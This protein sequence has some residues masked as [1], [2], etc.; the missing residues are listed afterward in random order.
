M[1]KGIKNLF[2][3]GSNK[4]V[5][6]EQSEQLP[7]EVESE[8]LAAEVKKT[9]ERFFPRVDFSDPENFARYG[10]AEKYYEDAISHIYKTFPYDGSD[11]EKSLWHREA[12]YL[13]NWFFDTLYPR[14]TGYVKLNSASPHSTTTVGGEGVY[15]S[16]LSPQHISLKGGPH[17]D[18]SA[19]GTPGKDEMSKQFPAKD[20][21]A[22]IWEADNKKTSNLEFDPTNGNTVEFWLKYDDANIV[23]SA[24]TNRAHVLFDMWNGEAIGTSGYVRFMVERLPSASGDFQ[25]TYMH[26]T[27]GVERLALSLTATSAALPENAWQHV[28]IT[29]KNSGSQILGQ[30]YY[31]G[32]FEAQAL[33]GADITTADVPPEGLQARIN[34]YLAPPKAGGTYAGLT[35]GTGGA[36]NVYF[37]EFRYWK[38]ERAEKNIGRFWFTQIS[39]GTNTDVNKYSGS[40]DPIDL[41][42]YYKFNEG[43]VD[44]VEVNALDA[45]VIDYSGRLSNGSISNYTVQVRSTGSAM[46]EATQVDSDDPEYKDPVLYSSHPS[47]STLM[48]TMKL[49]GSTHDMKNNAAFYHTMPN[50]ITEE[51]EEK[52]RFAIKELVQA[53]SSYFDTL[54]LQIE[55]LPN[56]KETHYSSM[57]SGTDKPYSFVNHLV[58]S[59]GMEAPDLF[60]EATAL[61][62]VMS[63]GEQEV[64]DL[65]IQEIKNI[66]YQN[67]YNNL[68][69]I[70]KSKGTEK[71]FRNLIRCFGVDEELIKINL[72]ADNTDYTLKDTKRFTVIKKNFMDCNDRDRNEGIA[73]SSENDGRLL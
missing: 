36:E 48:S 5:T 56:M 63:R 59:L 64:F 33:G 55:A 71:A 11:A 14:T 13:D 9:N 7:E 52:G 68:P 8:E 22:N 72:Y 34:G 2:G 70:Y 19:N 39:G 17:K 69:Y 49:S 31:N 25:V 57:E 53:L 15:A 37:D 47:V 51:D 4:I 65:K 12:S 23:N 60:V 28:A 26:G 27:D 21:K 66:I 67:I 18:P 44:T 54:H 16:F 73:Y 38:R 32:M 1:S 61:E 20:G 24:S 62:E 42:V 40:A 46:D 35:A 43:I 58:R 30:L 3:K 45:N 10:S 29:M 50:W 6:N 41:G